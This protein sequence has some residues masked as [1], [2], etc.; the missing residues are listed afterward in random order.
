ML[1]GIDLVRPEEAVV[2]Q[3]FHP[4]SKPACHA[5]DGKDRGK[6]VNGDAKLVVDHTR[7]EIDIRGNTL[8]TDVFVDDPFYFL[9]HSV[10]RVL[11]FDLKEV[12][13]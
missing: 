6:L 1:A 7:I 5:S 4:V 3:M 8:G 10:Q 11:A 9:R 12:I 2:S 13:G